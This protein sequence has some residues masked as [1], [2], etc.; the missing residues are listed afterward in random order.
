MS[1]SLRQ[2]LRPAP[3]IGAASGILWLLQLTGMTT[4][5]SNSFVAVLVSLVALL[6]FPGWLLARLIGVVRTSWLEETF[7]DIALGLGL[8]SALIF[9]AVNTPTNITSIAFFHTILVLLLAPLA[10]LA[11]WLRWRRR[12]SDNEATEP[13]VWRFSWLNAAYWLAAAIAVAAAIYVL[14]DHAAYYFGP[15]DRPNILAWIRHFL[16]TDFFFDRGFRLAPEVVFTT[17]REKVQTL[18][19]LAALVVHGADIPLDWA[20]L[21]DL[22]V[23]LALAAFVLTYLVAK[24]LLHDTRLALVAVALLSIWLLSD[25]DNGDTNGLGFML[26]LIEDKY[27][28]KHLLFPLSIWLYLRYLGRGAWQ[29]LVVLAAVLFSATVSHPLGIL[30]FALPTGLY[31]LFILADFKRADGKLVRRTTIVLGLTVLFVGAAYLQGREFL[32]TSNTAGLYAGSYDEMLSLR[33][34][35]D[36]EYRARRLLIFSL[37]YQLYIG[38]LHLISHPFILLTLACT[39]LLAWRWNSRLP[40]RFLLAAVLAPMIAVYMPGISTIVGKVISPWMLWRLLWIF[41]AP[42]VLAYTLGAIAD[43]VQR[44]QAIQAGRYPLAK[45]VPLVAVAFCESCWP[46]A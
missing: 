17:L 25:I 29:N 42:Y 41:P 16:T 5:V 11:M 37:D 8:A 45:W 35:L 21:I 32:T 23:I 33:G 18:N 27:V 14:V 38:S 36:T 39:P 3:V 6:V 46:H 26:R 1:P 20:Y 31:W 44:H 13:P 2:W 12:L 28:L 24:E 22:P 34:G 40:E 15:T 10:L 19:V 43:A 30:F 9:V 7:V 4:A